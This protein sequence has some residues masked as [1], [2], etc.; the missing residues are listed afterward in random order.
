M[1]KQCFKR[2]FLIFSHLKNYIKNYK[3]KNETPELENRMKTVV[4]GYPQV[5]SENFEKYF[6]EK[7]H[8]H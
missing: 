7:L 5:L 2:Q 8:Q 1:S 3:K 6:P 4:L